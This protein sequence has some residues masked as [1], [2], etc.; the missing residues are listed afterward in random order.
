MEKNDFSVCSTG[1][2]LIGW[3]FKENTRLWC[4]V[5]PFFWFVVFEV[6][7]FVRTDG[8]DGVGRSVV[9]TGSQK[10]LYA[11][12][13][14]KRSI[15]QS[16][17]QKFHLPSTPSNGQNNVLIQNDNV[18]M[19]GVVSREANSQVVCFRGGIHEEDHGKFGRHGA[20]KI[21]KVRSVF[22]WLIDLIDMVL[23]FFYDFSPRKPVRKCTWWFFVRTAP[24][25]REGSVSWCT[26]GVTVR[27][28]HWP[29]GGDS[30]QL[31]KILEWSKPFRNPSKPIGT[32]PQYRVI[33]NNSGDKRAINSHDKFSCSYHVR[34][35]WYSPG[36][37]RRS[38]RT[39]WGKRHFN[40]KFKNVLLLCHILIIDYKK[41]KKHNETS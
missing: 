30:G 14:A 9:R 3:F 35:C 33:S 36:T 39:L 21:G 16:I 17:E 34:R 7:P 13:K 4:D 26:A 24:C 6:V 18:L 12:N 29:L 41:T 32:A 23:R 11:V 1:T 2:D 38:H 19:T 37:A 27:W 31:R 5:N 8:R 22:A 20:E 40:F 25:C 28:R 10:G 15:N